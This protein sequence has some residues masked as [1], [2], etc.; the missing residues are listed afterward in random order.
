MEIDEPK[1]GIV[2]PDFKL[3]SQDGSIISLSDYLNR[4]NVYLFFVREFN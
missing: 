3:P 2:A 4:L 1:V